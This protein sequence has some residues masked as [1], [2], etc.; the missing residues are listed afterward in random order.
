[1]KYIVELEFKHRVTDTNLM[2]TN[3]L[4]EA[5]AKLF[6]EW[7][8]LTTGERKNLETLRILESWNPDEDAP[9][10][11]DGNVVIDLAIRYRPKERYADAWFGGEVDVDYVEE[12]MTHGFP[13]DDLIYLIKEWGSE[14]INQ[15]E[16][17]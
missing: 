1:M 10:H 14:A 2:E 15:L 3:S 16:E 13:V 8:H 11:Y 6:D 12:C 9:D 5:I 7:R 17:L 4:D